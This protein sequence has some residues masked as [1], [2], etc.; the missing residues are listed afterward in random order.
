[1]TWVPIIII[2]AIS[3][4]LYRRGGTSAGTLWRDLGVPA[5]MVAVMTLLGGLHW[6]LILCFGL[7]FASCTTYF[8]KK[9]SDACWWNW[10][11]VGLAFSISML[12]WAWAT[13]HWLGFGVRT[14]VCTALITLWSEF[15]G[16][17]VAEEFGRGFIIVATLLLL[18]M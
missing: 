10:L 14:V 17:D 18:F 12:P 9:G 7:L 2:S 5:C 16:W 1:M 3:G 6:S 15:M 13:G 11:L 8:K 4:Y